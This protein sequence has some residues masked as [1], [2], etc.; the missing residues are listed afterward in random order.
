MDGEEANISVFD[1]EKILKSIL[2]PVHD[3]VDEMKKYGE[4]SKES[5]R[6]KYLLT[7]V[8]ICTAKWYSCNRKFDLKEKITAIGENYIGL[9]FGLEDMEDGKFPDNPNELKEIYDF[10]YDEEF[11]SD[12]KRNAREIY[13]VLTGN[14]NRPRMFA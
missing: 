8:Y 14:F 10:L 1:S 6:L 9:V 3:K 13:D 5:E 11:I 12:L 4:I 2:D 7:G